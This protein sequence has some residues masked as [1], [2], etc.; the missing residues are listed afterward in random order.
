MERMSP[1]LVEALNEQLYTWA[2][3]FADGRAAPATSPLYN[4]MVGKV[5]NPRRGDRVLVDDAG[6]HAI[7]QAMATIKREAPRQFDVLQLEAFAQL[8][9]DGLA[10]QKSRARRLRVSVATYERHLQ[11]GRLFLTGLLFGP[12]IAKQQQECSA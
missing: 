2:L 4:L 10:L 11:R 3:L 5:Q 8:G 7:E 1:R 6:S 9:G 12:L